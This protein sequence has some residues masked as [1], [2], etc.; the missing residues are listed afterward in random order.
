MLRESLLEMLL[1]A[2]TGS[3]QAEMQRLGDRHCQVQV[4]P[5]HYKLWL[6]ALCDALVT[7]NSEFS[8]ANERI[9]RAAM[10]KGVDW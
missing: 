3:G 2:Q 6:K 10:S 1:I 9:W 4:Q 5:V 7:R 8:T